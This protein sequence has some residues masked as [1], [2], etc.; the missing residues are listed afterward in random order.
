MIY[1]AVQVRVAARPRYLPASWSPLACACRSRSATFKREA[2]S[3]DPIPDPR[4]GVLA[5]ELKHTLDKRPGTLRV[6]RVLRRVLNQLVQRAKLHHL[7]RHDGADLA[8]R[9]VFLRAGAGRERSDCRPHHQQQFL[10]VRCLLGHLQDHL[11]LRRGL[12]SGRGGGHVELLHGR[13]D[14]LLRFGL[15]RRGV[16]RGSDAG[17]QVPGDHHD[18]RYTTK[19]L[20]HTRSVHPNWISE[21]NIF[22]A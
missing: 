22:T 8:L 9:G 13:A 1:D 16:A 6:D 21:Q 3:S 7:G 11:L 2:A 15:G 14:H 20:Q 12:R 5:P 10:P 19:T 17:S 4:V 18:K